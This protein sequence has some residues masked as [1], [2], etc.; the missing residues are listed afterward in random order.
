MRKHLFPI[1]AVVV[2][3]VLWAVFYKELPAELPTHWGPSGEIDDYTSK[4]GTFFM[5]HGLI[6]GMYVLM[7]FLPNLDPKK[8]NYK[9]FD[10]GYSAIVNGMLLIFV[11]IDF[12]T[13]YIGLGHKLEMAKLICLLVGAL[14]IVIG[15]YMQQVKTNYFVGI[16]T[17]WTLSNETVWKKT[18]RVGARSFMISGLLIML[19]FFLPMKWT[20]GIVIGAAILC[21]V[22]PI[23]YSYVIY[24]KIVK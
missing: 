20:A 15:N 22:I 18:H 1:V 14:F 12:G 8:A 16:K 24:K 2:S 9:F 11:A 17:P 21:S 23:A 5:L 4:L 10:K 13:I 3:F 19:S 7:V 6:I